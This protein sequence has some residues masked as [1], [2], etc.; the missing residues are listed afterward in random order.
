M[1][2]SHKMRQRIRSTFPE[3][4]TFSVAAIALFA[5]VVGY[6]LV[7]GKDS[8]VVHADASATTEKA[9]SLAGA[10]VLPTNPK[11]KI[12]PK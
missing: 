2:P 12:E 6:L 5:A 10:K 11:L 4:M 7:G 1:A 9:A 8:G 3:W